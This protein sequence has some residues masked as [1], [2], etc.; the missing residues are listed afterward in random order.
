MTIRAVFFDVG[1]VL[2]RVENHDKRH[3]W[4][5]YL[6]L[7]R[8]EVTRAVF[9]SEEAA[10][11][12]VGEIPERDMWKSVTRRLGLRDDQ[13]ADFHRDFWAGERFDVELAQ[14][15]QSLRPR[16]KT[17]IISN[18]WSDAR[19][20][21]NRKFNLDSYVDDAIYSAEVKLVKPDARIFQLALARLGVQAKGAVFVDDM[22]ENVRAAQS[23]GMKGVQFK[24]TMQAITEVK[25]HL[26]EHST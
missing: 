9:D 14:F 1:G 3:E 20:V 18:A 25:G 11:A 7:P 8:G 23:L 17:G 19:P 22:L 15:I 21:L 6:G 4:E 13:L 5:A 10:R 24:N 12:A 16:Y 2:I 26:D